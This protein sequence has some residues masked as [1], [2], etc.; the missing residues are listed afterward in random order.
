MFG[1]YFFLKKE[2]VKIAKYGIHHFSLNLHSEVLKKV[3][4]AKQSRALSLFSRATSNF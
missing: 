4:F 3:N 2:I 1:A